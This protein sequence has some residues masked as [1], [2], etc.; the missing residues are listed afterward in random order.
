METIIFVTV[1]IFICV[2]I[3]F[4]FA[5]WYHTFKRTL[6]NLQGEIKRT[7]GEEQKEWI[8]K[9]RKLWLSLIPFVRY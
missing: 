5:E 3:L 8:R 6:K 2:G 4:R 9:K 1:L 7:S